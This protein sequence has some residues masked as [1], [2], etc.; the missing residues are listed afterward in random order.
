MSTHLL[1]VLCAAATILAIAA[2]GA[3]SDLLEPDALE[4]RPTALLK[5]LRVSPTAPPLAAT[6]TSFF[7]VAGRSSGMDIW[8]RARPGRRDSTRLME[9]RLGPNSLGRKPN[10]SAFSQGDSIRIT[11]TVRD[12]TR[13]I[14]DFQPSGLRFA[15]SDPARLKLFF[16]EVSDDLDDDGKVDADDEAAKRKLAIWR[17]EALGL[18]WFRIASA[19]EVNSREVKADLAGFTGYCLSY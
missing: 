18:S 11:I 14:I 10:G 19:V 13:I 5:L 2:C 3:A 16:A 4:E 6:T 8:Y 12:P 17:Q 9:F 1:R 7:A 15:A